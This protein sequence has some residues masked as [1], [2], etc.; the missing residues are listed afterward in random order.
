M[1]TSLIRKKSGGFALIALMA[2]LVTIML[3]FAGL[4]Y[5]VMTNARQMGRN[6][7]FTATQA[8]AEGATEVVFAHMDRDYLY[9]NLNSISNYVDL[10]P[11]MTNWPVQYTFDVNV[12]I[13][14]PTA[15]LS[16]LSSQYTNLIGEPQTNTITV[17]A[18]PVGQLYNVPATVTQSYI[19]ATVPAFQFAIF[20]NI[21]LEIDPGGNMPVQGP[22]FSNG[23][24]WSGT[25]NVNYSKTVQAAAQ[26]TITG[27]DPFCS[28]KS[29]SG[30]P[31][32]NFLLVSTPPQP[33]SNV[34]PLILPIGASS[35]PNNSNSSTNVAAIV[36]IPPPSVVAPQSIAY[37]QTNQVYDFN[38]ASLLVSNVYYGTNGSVPWGNNFTVYL[39]DSIPVPASVVSQGV[40]RHWVQLTN[41]SYI[42][43][44][45][46]FHTTYWTNYVPNFQF[47]NNM[48][49]IKWVDATGTNFVWYAGFSFLT[50]VNFYDF[51]EGA[52]AQ[53]AQLSVSN[54][55]LWLMNTNANGGKNWST[56]L[57]E[58]IGHGIDSIFID[59]TVPFIGQHQLPVVRVV[60][61]QL[62]PCTTN[63]NVTVTGTNYPT[64][65]TRGFTVVT[66][67]PLYVKGNYNVQI[68]GGS[69]V[70]GSHNTASTYPA[71]FMADSIT[72]LSA[73]WDQTAGGAGQAY[74]SRAATSTTINAACL[75]GIVQSVGSHYS[76]G[77]ENFLRLLENWGGSTL[78]YNG[79]ILVMFPSQVATNLWQAPS[80]AGSYYGVPTRNWA[81]DTN[82]LTAAGLPPLTPNFRT[83]VRN[84]W[85]TY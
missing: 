28:G 10:A 61:G 37:E 84:S 81:F 14:E 1:K 19:F 60:D 31:Q 45:I 4:M 83:V 48:T 38:A 63:Y 50:N 52:I 33:V 39:Q 15:V 34:N 71:A 29:D 24:I 32:A 43:T 30:T 7:A 70:L 13:G 59:N 58:D 77:V 68:A 51:R 40:A 79:S 22:V 65:I 78:T 74:T 57:C 72:V 21:N 82:F 46:N 3:V 53:A 8:A 25:G 5:W 16:F 36:N 9:G 66:P 56:E 73:N 62:L 23:G 64:I 11:Y 41:D 42:V 85:L 2:C 17:T 55:D 44:N 27:T 49:T 67:Q 75:E 6:R 54:L 26:V 20:Y 12:D 35:D 47:T 80:G 76:G 18:T 69:P